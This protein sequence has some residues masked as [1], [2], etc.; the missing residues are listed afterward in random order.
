LKDF[1]IISHVLVYAKSGVVFLHLQ[2]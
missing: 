2:H 1:V